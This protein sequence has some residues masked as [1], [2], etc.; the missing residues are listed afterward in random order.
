MAEMNVRVD[1][2]KD[3]IKAWDWDASVKKVRG[4][5]V[6]SWRKVSKSLLEELYQAKLQ[7]NRGPG[8]P[9]GRYTWKQFCED[10]FGGAPSRRTIDTWLRKYE[11]GDSLDVADEA[12]TRS[13]GVSAPK[14]VEVDSLFVQ[15]AFA[16]KD[17][18]Y[19]VRVSVPEYPDVLFEE[20]LQV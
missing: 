18:S 12:Q 5:Y 2:T 14:P 13:V 9:H 11:F 7:I 19:T 10:A 15:K 6:G 1:I 16:N 17:G 3:E 20:I 4:L 8:N